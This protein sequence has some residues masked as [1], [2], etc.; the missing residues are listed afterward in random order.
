[1]DQV[2]TCGERRYGFDAL[3]LI[4]P[5]LYEHGASLRDRD[6]GKLDD[7]LDLLAPIY[8]WFTEGFDTST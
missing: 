1:M 6:Q 4:A 2:E 3:V 5:A 8:G 7:A